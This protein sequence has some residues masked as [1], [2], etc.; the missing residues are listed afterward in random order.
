[1]LPLTHT[2]FASSS[3]EDE[4][5]SLPA[6]LPSSHASLP[7]RIP[8]PQIGVQATPE[9]SYPVLHLHVKLPAVL[10][11]V[12]W[13]WQLCLSVASVH[14]STSTQKAPPGT[15]LLRQPAWHLQSDSKALPT[16][17]LVFEFVGHWVQREYHDPGNALNSFA[18]Q[19][20]HTPAMSTLAKGLGL[21]VVGTAVN[22]S[23][24]DPAAHVAC[25]WHLASHV[26]MVLVLYLPWMQGTHEPAADLLMPVSSWPAGHA[27]KGTQFALPP[28]AYLPSSHATH[29]AFHEPVVFL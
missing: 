29:T 6:V 7:Y 13:M 14:S 10:E 22:T 25:A 27:L 19:F 20:L 1:M 11:Q 26:L 21:A 3:Q 23:R 24:Y 2:K 18:M 28:R 12:A 16:L 9:P 4:Q 5:P 8:S 17:P 15:E